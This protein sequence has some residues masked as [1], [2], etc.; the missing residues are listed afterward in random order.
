MPPSP[1][2]STFIISTARTNKEAT[3]KQRNL[4]EPGGGGGGGG[5]D[6]GVGVGVV[7][8]RQ[9]VGSSRETAFSGIW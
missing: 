8:L 7:L 9:R 2:R 4:S 6:G 5:A 1:S 3:Q